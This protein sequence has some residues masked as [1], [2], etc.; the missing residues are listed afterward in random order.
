MTSR[1]D[2][3]S[4]RARALTILQNFP[5]VPSPKVATR[6]LESGTLVHFQPRD[7]VIHQGDSTTEMYFLLYGSVDILQDGRHIGRRSAGEVVGEFAAIE[8]SGPRSATVVAA[9]GGMVTALRV[10]DD[11]FRAIANIHRKLWEHL[12]RSLVEKL[13]QRKAPA[14]RPREVP[15]VFIASSSESKAIARALAAHLRSAG[16]A[17]DVWDD[18]VFQPGGHIL[19]TL[20]ARAQEVDFCIAVAAPDDTTFSRDRVYRSPRDNVLF[21]FG[22]FMGAM[23]HEGPARAF[24]VLPSGEATKLPSDYDGSVWLTYDSASLDPQTATEATA[25]TLLDAIRRIGPR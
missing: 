21:E 14:P 20:V 23:G 11:R 13:R 22:L 6:L 25:G 8:S 15:R 4:G 9:P 2:G 19:G 1:F 7:H 5:L 12:A 24:L 16:L 3:E 10:D 18:G 17:V